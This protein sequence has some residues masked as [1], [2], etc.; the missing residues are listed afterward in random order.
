MVGIEVIPSWRRCRGT[1]ARLFGTAIRWTGSC[2]VLG[3][4][5]AEIQVHAEA[6][7]TT[8]VLTDALAPAGRVPGIMSESVGEAQEKLQTWRRLG[9]GRLADRLYA[10][11][12]SAW[13]WGVMP[14][15]ALGQGDAASPFLTDGRPQLSASLRVLL[16]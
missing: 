6:R 7:S 15:S 14:T 5:G 12:R 1:A 9:T 3:D 16:G 4:V 13:L 8:V 10:R 2:L 11:L